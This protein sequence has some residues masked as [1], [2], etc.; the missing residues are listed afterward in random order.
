M[1]PK[2]F[3]SICYM[4]VV[5]SAIWIT[6][7]IAASKQATSNSLNIFEVAEVC[8]HGDAFPNSRTS[9]D[10]LEKLNAYFSPQPIWKVA[11]SLFY[12][13]DVN[14]KASTHAI[15]R[16]SGYLPFNSADYSLQDIP[17]WS[18]IFD[19]TVHDRNDIVLGVLQDGAC[20]ASAEAGGIRPTLAERCQA[21][22][23][24]KFATHL[25]ACLTGF[26][27]NAILMYPQRSDGKTAYQ[28][29]IEEIE[30]RNDPD[31]DAR[32]AQLTERHM[33]ALWMTAIC[34]S[35]PAT[36]YDDDLQPMQLGNLDNSDFSIA[37][38]ARIMKKGHDAALG[39]AAR[40][41]DEWAMQS[42]YP[43][44]PKRDPEY[45]QAM[46]RV[47]PLLLHR[48]MA[49]VVGGTFLSD[50]ERMWHAVKA[51]SIERESSPDLDLADYA[52][53]LKEGNIP[54]DQMLSDYGGW[55]S[56]TTSRSA[57]PQFVRSRTA[58][59]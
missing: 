25:D 22:E 21:R 35:L 42:Y 45:W 51:Y 17:T 20:R 34:S 9:H 41:G 55:N 7:E 39:I 43:P 5:A 16:R 37:E 24:F 18:D 10:C 47:N 56:T 38:F 12:Y 11:G 49:S 3:I 52:V 44:H 28:N 23:L 27:R 36:A 29:S 57:T 54:L 59:S 30:R 48:W 13:V 4:V 46:Q 14:S 58:T 15:N 26:E 6:N 33:H 32:I 19:G 40:A 8:D 1:K 53:D 50:D 2:R 31:Q